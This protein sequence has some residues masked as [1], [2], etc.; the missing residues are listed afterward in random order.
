[1][2]LCLTVYVSHLAPPIFLN[3]SPV[4]I[5]PSP[6]LLEKLAVAPA[7]PKGRDEGPILYKRVRYAVNGHQYRQDA[8][9]YFQ[10]LPDPFRLHFAFS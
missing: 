6:A 4:K 2:P 5:V 7:S 8:Y 3:L 10:V 1:M 9:R